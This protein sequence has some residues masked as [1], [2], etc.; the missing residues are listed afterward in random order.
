MRSTYKKLGPYIREVDVRNDE[1]K[2]T[3]LLGV[4]TQKMFIDSIANTIGTDF[5]KYKV[6]K[7][8]QFTYVP[9]TS[10]R[11]D[12]IGL[13]LLETHDW[14][15]VSNVY[16][17]FEIMDEEELLPEYLM[18]W[19]RRPEFDRY[20]RFK[21]H[22]SV[23]ELFGWDE[24][25]DVELPIPS[26]EKQRKIVKEYQTIV[27]RIR[28][29]ERLNEKLEEA[30]QAIYKQW[31]VDFEFP[32]TAEYAES[33]GKPELAGQP[34]KSRGGE[35][36]HNDVL[37]QK[38]P[39]GWD[40]RSIGGYCKAIT[41]GGTPSRSEPTYWNAHDIPWLK[42]GEISNNIIT[43]A[44]EYISKLGYKHSSAKLLP[45][46][47][48]VMALYG[49]TAGQ[50]GF[51]KFPSSANQACCAMMCS[52][53]ADAAYLYYH[54]LQKQGAIANM[55]NGG[56]QNNLS[57]KIVEQ[58]PL[59]VPEEGVQ[60][61]VLYKLINQRERIERESS[62]VRRLGEMLLYRIAVS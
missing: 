22:G 60:T 18:M 28:L 33:I 35:M 2:Q 40:V 48:V 23:R 53:S 47:T 44:E 8:G 34:Y 11:G 39:K 62:I 7:R 56:A 5:K 29:N 3:N 55:A 54:L 26:I 12:K 52:R 15:L 57:K 42:T 38:I 43:T 16:T 46:D 31:F 17:V 49:V 13:A 51:L 30:A 50:I 37:E 10:R 59:L 27:S 4:S 20:A 45:V 6:V 14:G 1:D 36:E 9:D 19:F 41:S 24:I 61:T 25:C 32:M 58:L 21:S